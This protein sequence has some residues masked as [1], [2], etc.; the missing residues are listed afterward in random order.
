ML[1]QKLVLLQTK[2]NVT[3]EPINVFIKISVQTGQ[4]E[5]ICSEQLHFQ[6]Y[7]FLANNEDTKTTILSHFTTILHFYT[8]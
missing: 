1:Y 7:K 8:P 3:K 4:T 5:D 6:S 2:N